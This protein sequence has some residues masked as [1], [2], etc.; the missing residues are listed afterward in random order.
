MRNEFFIDYLKMVI[1]CNNKRNYEDHVKNYRNA[2]S[3]IERL[4]ITAAINA[5]NEIIQTSMMQLEIEE[6]R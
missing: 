2:S 1:D 4:L 5:R 3:D 6:A